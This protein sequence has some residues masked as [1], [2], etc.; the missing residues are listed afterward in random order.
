MEANGIWGFSYNRKFEIFYIA[1]YKSDFN[2]KYMYIIVVTHKI[3]ISYRTCDILHFKEKKY[4]DWM[5]N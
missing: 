4:F 5:Y 3:R 2:K 1:Y